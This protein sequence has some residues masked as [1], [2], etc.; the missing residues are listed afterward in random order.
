[1]SVTFETLRG[2]AV[3]VRNAVLHG[4]AVQTASIESVDGFVERLTRIVNDHRVLA[5]SESRPLLDVLEQVR[6]SSRLGTPD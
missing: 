4:G 2:R 1:L 5:L 3:R 6:V